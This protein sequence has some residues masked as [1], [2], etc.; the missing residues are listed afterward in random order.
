MLRQPHRCHMGKKIQFHERI[1][2]SLQEIED[3]WDLVTDDNGH[4]RVRHTWSHHDPYRNRRP[5]EGEAFYEIDEFLA[6]N[7]DDEAKQKLK[8]LLGGA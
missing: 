8:A 6:G 4:S 3:W 5:D 2:G 7:A 1:K